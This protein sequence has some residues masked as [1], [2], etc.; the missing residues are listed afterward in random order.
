MTG[1][2]LLSGP[3]WKLVAFARP[4]VILSQRSGKLLTDLFDTPLMY[5]LT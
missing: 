5:D 4:C 1:P 2:K 3:A